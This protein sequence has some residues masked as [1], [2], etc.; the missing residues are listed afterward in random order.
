MEII[1][2]CNWIYEGCLK[3]DKEV[4]KLP[5]LTEASAKAQADYD[6]SLGLEVAK[7]KASGESVSIIDRLAK[8]NC[9]DALLSR[10]SAEG[11][12]K[13]CYANI[14]SLKARINAFQS[15]NKYLADLPVGE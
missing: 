5:D 1:Q 15:I 4:S 3:L 8:G 14:E 6:K 2:V 7:L 12:L 10:I 9:S 11:R 13:A